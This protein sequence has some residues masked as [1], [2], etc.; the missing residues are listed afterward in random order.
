[1]DVLA[2]AVERPKK[3]NKLSL[4]FLT[5][6]VPVDSKTVFDDLWFPPRYNKKDWKVKN[7]KSVELTSTANNNAAVKEDEPKKN[8]SGAA[9]TNVDE[10]KK[11][12]TD[13]AGSKRTQSPWMQALT[14]S[15]PEEPSQASVTRVLMFKVSD[16]GD[17]DG[18]NA[19]SRNEPEK[20][21]PWQRV[22]QAARKYDRRDGLC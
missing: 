6:E 20:S 7:N 21:S 9:A 11:A 14:G 4:K 3:S 18:G 5:I 22:C 15:I 2:L 10:P 12:A 17:A 19:V 16:D 13:K 8:T 1:M